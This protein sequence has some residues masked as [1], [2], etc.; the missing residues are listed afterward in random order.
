VV[1]GQPPK[2]I[3]EPPHW[4][5]CEQESMATPQIQCGSWLACDGDLSAPE[6]N[7]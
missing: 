2:I 3:T 5:L 1:V 4:G 6:N 7:D